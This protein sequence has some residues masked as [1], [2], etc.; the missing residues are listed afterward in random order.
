MFVHNRHIPQNRVRQDG[1]PT[2]EA[3]K[4]VS[5]M[6]SSTGSKVNIPEIF[7][8]TTPT[9]PAV[10]AKH[11]GI[12][13]KKEDIQQNGNGVSPNQSPTIGKWKIPPRKTRNT[14]SDSA[15]GDDNGT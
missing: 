15:I 1:I 5:S 6:K 13:P 4:A 11:Q 7:G 9:K 14:G 2:E 3:D 10:P 8:R 12:S